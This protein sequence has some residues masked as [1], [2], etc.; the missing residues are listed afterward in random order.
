MRL[1]V[2]AVLGLFLA[3]FLAISCRAQAPTTIIQFDKPFLFT[4]GTWDKKAQIENGT[5]RLETDGLTP[6]GGGGVNLAPPLDLLGDADDSPGLRVLVGPHNSLKTLKLMLTDTAGHAGT[7]SFFLPASSGAAVLVTPLD[8]AP[9]AHP[10]DSGKTGAPDL[11]KIMQWQLLGDWGGDGLVAVRV[12]AIVAVVPG[13]ALR[14]VRAALVQKDAEAAA[15]ARKDRQEARAKFGRTTVLSPVVEAVYAAA[16]DVLALQ[17]H[18]GKI[19]P[20]HLSVYTKQPGDTTHGDSA[21]TILMRGGQDIG[22]LIGPKKDGLVTFEGFSGDPLLTA[23]ADDPTNY[24]V[25]SADDPA[26]AAGVQPL[27]VGRKSKPDDWQQ[28]KRPGLTLLHRL[29]LQLPHPLTPGRTYTVSL[30]YLNVQTPTVT[31]AFD[32]G[33]VWSESVHVDQVGFRPD[34]PRKRAYLSLWRGTGNGYDFPAGLKFHLVDALTGKAVYNGVAGAAWAADKPETMHTT[35][36]FNN[37]SVAPMDFSDFHTPGRYRV[38]VDGIGCS[39][40]FAIG[41]DVWEKA[42]QTQMKGFY[43]QRSGVALGP[44][45][46]TFVRPADF[47]PSTPGVV[48]ITQSTYSI[49]D[50][51]DAQ[52]DLAKGDTGKP[53]PEAWGGYHDAGDWNPRRITHMRT[54]TFWQLELLDLFP[55]YFRTLS[56]HIP[57]TSPAPDLL[58]ECRFELSL[59]HRLQLPDGGVRFGIET[60]GDPIDGEVSWKQS[61]PAYVY[62]PDAQSSYLYAAIAARASRVLAAYDPAEAKIYRVS[63]LAAMCWAEA[64]RIKRQAAGTWA[65]LPIDVT[66]DRTLAAV[67]MYQLTSD[68]HW[69][70]VFLE[71]T[72]L[73]NAALIPFY[74][75]LQQRDIAFTYARL[76]ANLGDPQIKQNARRALLAD[77]DGAL[78]YAQNN[79]W[80]IASDDP[81]KPQF[82]GFYSTPHGAVSLV[83]AYTLTHDAKYLAGAVQACLFPAGANPSNLVYTSGVGA[84]PVRHPLNLD[85]RLTGQPAPV[86]L[87]TYGNVDLAR[88]G[89]QTWITWPITYYFAPVT[90]PAAADWPTTEAYFDVFFMPALDEFT[91]D[92]TMG[93][94]A[95]VWGYLAARK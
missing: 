26:F 9:F 15:Q 27:S 46:T 5:V 3:P 76:P 37:A 17:I 87:T 44:P 71:D 29:Y 84:N 64:D 70:S 62:A 40:P 89:D 6:K 81:G 59:F 4:Y 74:G 77:A 65:K 33:K 92:Q 61:M 47:K 23:E 43:N 63:A 21:A 20:S 94:N 85:S 25:R 30:V 31:L 36:N 24:I 73:K 66:E 78:T 11:S 18:S 12:E 52:K 83:R 86:G 55:A 10:N 14:A 38:S 48:S 58:N 16:A 28:P 50:G 41:A 51:G 13:A 69:H 60:N 45:Y 95:Y 34:D 79:A 39:Y 57:K 8:A 54:T 19:T 80:G 1:P 68:L 22:Y 90:Q 56:L 93:P 32:P 88:W 72:G 7:W 49:L 91:V 53:V 82:L 75:S 67:E 35:R 2:Y 42:F